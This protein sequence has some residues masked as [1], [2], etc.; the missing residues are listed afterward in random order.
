MATGIGRAASTTVVTGATAIERT[1][2]IEL[3]PRSTALPPTIGAFGLPPT[4]TISDTIARRR[5]SIRQLAMLCLDVGRM[6]GLHQAI[7]IWRRSAI[8]LKGSGWAPARRKRRRVIRAADSPHNSAV[9]R[10][11]RPR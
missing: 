6:T 2:R 4:A 8:A 7:C 9:S 11:A 1:E 10:C 5:S 3:W